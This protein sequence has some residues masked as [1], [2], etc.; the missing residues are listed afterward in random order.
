[1]SASHAQEWLGSTSRHLVDDSSDSLLIV[2]TISPTRLALPTTPVELPGS[3]FRMALFSPAPPSSHQLAFW[4]RSC[5]ST[6]A[7]CAS[8]G[9]EQSGALSS[10]CH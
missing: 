10:S 9:R 5:S 4:E 1:M 3:S 6:F 8:F 7:S 2:Q